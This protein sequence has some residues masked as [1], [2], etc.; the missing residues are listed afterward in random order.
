MHP[1]VYY[2]LTYSKLAYCV[3][4][5]NNSRDRTY[6]NHLNPFLKFIL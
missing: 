2:I 4:V 1:K 3:R 5:Y 6:I